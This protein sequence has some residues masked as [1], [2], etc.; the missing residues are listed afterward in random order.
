[1]N[2]RRLLCALLA[3]GLGLIF[4]LAYRSDYTLGNRLVRYLCGPAAYLRLKLALSQWLPVLPRELRGCL[5]SALWCIVGTSL[6]GGWKIR[7]GVR[8]VVPLALLPPA[9]NAGWEFVQWAGWTD[10][11]ADWL[12]VCAGLAGWMVVQAVFFRPARPAEEIPLQWSWRTG[13]MLAGFAC[14]GFAD[15]WK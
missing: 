2:R 3:L 13:V 12:D 9:L 11:H 8:H 7:L 15:V 5:P 1:M 10:G 6:L 14:M 4:Y